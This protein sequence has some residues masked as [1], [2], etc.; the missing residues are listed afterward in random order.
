MDVLPAPTAESTPVA[1]GS[2]SR[3]AVAV[4]VVGW[5]GVLTGL[6]FITAAAQ[7]V[8]H[9]TFQG[10]FLPI[11]WVGPVLTMFGAIRSRPRIVLLSA[12]ST[13]VLAIGAAVDV[14]RNHRIAGRYE[15][16]L[17]GS[18]ALV[19]AAAWLVTRSSAAPAA[20]SPTA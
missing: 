15:F 16:L 13:V 20:P 5:L 1:P 10:R 9:A 2:L 8:D 19:T 3:T 4:I 18:A 7:I 6:G 17:A 14:S 11:F 12:V